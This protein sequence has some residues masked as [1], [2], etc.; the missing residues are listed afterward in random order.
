MRYSMSQTYVNMNFRLAK[1][2]L[3]WRKSKTILSFRTKVRASKCLVLLFVIISISIIMYNSTDCLER[4]HL[5]KQNLAHVAYGHR[6]LPA[7]DIEERIHQKRISYIQSARDSVLKSNDSVRY[8]E[9]LPQYRT[10][11][12]RQT[13]SNVV[14]LSDLE[15][16]SIRGLTTRRCVRN[17]N[18]TATVTVSNEIEQSIT[19]PLLPVTKASNNKLLQIYIEDQGLVVSMSL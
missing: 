5:I 11:I 2:P 19:E 7:G 8:F 9:N 18:I 16:L 10:W 14:H 3:V 6:I 15:V 1:Q 12:L 4:L 13:E 17:N